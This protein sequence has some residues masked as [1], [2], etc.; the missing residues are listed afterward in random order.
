M[1]FHTTFQKMPWQLFLRISEEEAGSSPHSRVWPWSASPAHLGWV[2]HY[3]SS[4]HLDP[5]IYF[6]KGTGCLAHRSQ[7]EGVDWAGVGGEACN[8]T[9][10]AS[11]SWANGHFYSFCLVCYGSLTSYPTFFWFSQQREDHETAN[12][13]AFPSV[14]P[15]ELRPEEW[16]QA[17]STKK[18]WTGAQLG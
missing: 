8:S 14:M 5:N 7:G 13:G 4:G 2:C 1:S 16:G 10:L 3:D 9:L 15:S 11:K 12:Q 18:Q 17:L 6:H